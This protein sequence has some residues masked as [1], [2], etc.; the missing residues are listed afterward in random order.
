MGES[1]CPGARGLH[2]K[3]CGE[4]LCEGL[5]ARLSRAGQRHG[6]QVSRLQ[7]TGCT[8]DRA[9]QGGIRSTRISESERVLSRIDERPGAR[10]HAASGTAS[11]ARSRPHSSSRTGAGTRVRDSFGVSHGSGSASSRPTRSRSSEGNRDEGGGRRRAGN[12]GC[13]DSSSGTKRPDS[14]F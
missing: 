5:R 7:A 13:N 2:C 14:H 1:S 11:G 12:S 8:R 10:S 9:G 6:S 3:G 4:D